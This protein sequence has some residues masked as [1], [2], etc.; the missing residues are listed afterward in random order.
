MLYQYYT[1]FKINHKLLPIF[2]RIKPI[3]HP[4]HI[5]IRAC[6]YVSKYECV[7]PENVISIV[8]AD[9]KRTPHPYGT[10]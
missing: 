10:F 5:L 8:E 4:V 7:T 6:L 9:I 2:K 3:S 1:R